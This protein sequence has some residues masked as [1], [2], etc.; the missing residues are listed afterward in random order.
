MN[1]HVSSAVAKGIFVNNRWQPARTGRTL[2]VVAP[3]DGRVFSHIAAGGP[4]DVDAAVQAARFAIERGA[5][6]RAA[7]LRRIFRERQ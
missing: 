7:A 6:G 2:P 4:E 5:W 1:I 3:A